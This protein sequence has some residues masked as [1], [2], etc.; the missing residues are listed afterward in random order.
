MATINRQL[1][2]KLIQGN[3]KSKE[4]SAGYVLVRYQNRTKY[5]IPGVDLYNPN[6][7]VNCFDYAVFSSKRKY[8]E[9]LKSET[10]GG[11]D[12]LWGSQN[13]L[14]DEKKR[15]QEELWDEVKGFFPEDEILPKGAERL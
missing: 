4:G 2:D 5:G 10:I 8:E 9:F 1:A 14:I 6:A 13:F 7:E 15:K 12:I 11:V 3:G